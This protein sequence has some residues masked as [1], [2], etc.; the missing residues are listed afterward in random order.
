MPQT[1]EIG[2]LWVSPAYVSPL[3]V[4]SFEG[5]DGH[6]IYIEVCTTMMRVLSPYG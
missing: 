5:G 4:L 1:V 3:S 6:K 2:E